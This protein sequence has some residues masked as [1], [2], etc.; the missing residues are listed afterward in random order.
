MKPSNVK[1]ITHR[2]PLIEMGMSRGDCL[3]W[4]LAKGYPM[5]SKSACTFCPYHDEET[6]SDMKRNDPESWAQACMV[7]EA[8]RSGF[9]GGKERLFVH[10]SRKPL[11]EV[12]LDAAY[13][14]GQTD[15]FL[16][17][18]EGMCGL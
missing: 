7:D 4:M 3:A 6:W 17:E 5:P 1:Y 18:C 13:D 10:R 16:D 11:A 9:A 12:R 15:M 14:R 8:I 2:W